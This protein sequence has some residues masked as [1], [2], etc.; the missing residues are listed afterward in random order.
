VASDPLDQPLGAKRPKTFEEL[1]AEELEK[2]GEPPLET[3]EVEVKRPAGRPRGARARIGKGKGK[4]GGEE[5]GASCESNDAA[6]AAPAPAPAP[7]AAPAAPA[8][9]TLWRALG[10]TIRVRDAPEGIAVQLYELNKD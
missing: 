6:A 1:L 7:A 8:E 10:G 2:A 9:G 3:T 5:N 4:S